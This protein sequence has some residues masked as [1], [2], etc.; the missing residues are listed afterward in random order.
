MVM[1]LTKRFHGK[2]VLDKTLCEMS[3]IPYPLKIKINLLQTATHN[4]LAK[5]TFNL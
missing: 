1:L 2:S 5:F 4:T 3:T